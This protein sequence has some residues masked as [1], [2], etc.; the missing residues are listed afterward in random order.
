MACTCTDTF[1]TN[2][3]KDLMG[4]WFGEFCNEKKVLGNFYVRAHSSI[5][6][7]IAFVESRISFRFFHVAFTLHLTHWRLSLFID[8]VNS[9]SQ[10]L[11]L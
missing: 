7:R 11:M 6:V 4:F 9:S 8:Y 1:L 5:M 3:V 2:E 10:N